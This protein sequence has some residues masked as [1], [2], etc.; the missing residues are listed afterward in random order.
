MENNAKSN[1]GVTVSIIALESKD[2]ETISYLY[3]EHGKQ[4][5]TVINPYLTIAPNIIVT[6]QNESISG[7]PKAVF[8][9][10]PRD[11]GNLIFSEEEN[12]LFDKYTNNIVL[13][14]YIKYYIGAHEFINDIFRYTLWFETHSQYNELSDIPEIEN[15][16][17]K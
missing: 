12:E 10:M 2:R 13:R 9:S 16:L 14:K 15:V 8:G 3:S 7:F 1:A 6:S 4:M 17:I 11:G 5:A